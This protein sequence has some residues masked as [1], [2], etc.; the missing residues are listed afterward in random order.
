DQVAIRLMTESLVHRGPDDCGHF[1][2]G[3]IGL[4]FRR[5]AILDLSPAGHQPMVSDDGRFV[6]VFNGEIYNYL[7]L[8]KEL[9][10]AGYSFRSTGDS[11]VLLNAYR[12]WGAESLSRL[13]GMWAFLVY[14][15]IQR[16]LFGSRDRFGVKPLFVHWNR[17][18]VL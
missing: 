5:L 11:E 8:R 13:N 7:E 3:R 2:E 16:S 6:I 15:R 1:S 9:I 10:D 18:Q 14:D 4:G 12:H 17:E